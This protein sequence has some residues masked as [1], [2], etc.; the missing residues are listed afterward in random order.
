VTVFARAVVNSVSGDKQCWKYYVSSIQ[1]VVVETSDVGSG[2]GSGPGST[3]SRN[4]YVGGPSLNEKER[5]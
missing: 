1:D 3:R 4:D 2:G 5:E